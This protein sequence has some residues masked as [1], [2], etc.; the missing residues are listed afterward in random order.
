MRELSALDRRV[1][2]RSAVA[3]IA[4]FNNAVLDCIFQ[5]AAIPR[6]AVFQ[7]DRAVFNALVERGGELNRLRDRQRAVRFE[8]R[9]V[10]AVD[11]AVCPCVADRVC[12]PCRRR[13]IDEGHIADEFRVDIRRGVRHDEEVGA[14]RLLRDRNASAAL[15]RDAQ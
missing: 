15:I 12:V 14:V 13:H 6:A 3:E 7:R 9:R 5:I 11:Q 4:L 8:V 2:R 10:H 1:Q